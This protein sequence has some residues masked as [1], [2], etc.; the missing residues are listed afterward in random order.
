M[1]HVKTED[2]TVT[3]Y[4]DSYKELYH[5]K[6]GAVE[7]AIKKYVEPCRIIEL[8]EARAASGKLRILDICFGIGYNAIAAIDAAQPS[9]CRVEVISLELHKN[10]LKEIGSL[11]PPLKNYGLAKSVAKRC[12]KPRTR[13][14]SVRSGNTLLSLRLEDARK[15]IKRLPGK[16][17]AVFLDPF[18]VPK[19]PQLWSRDFF[20]AI[21]KLMT[22]SAVLATYSCAG[23]VRA[24]LVNAGFHITNGPELVKR[25][26]STLASKIVFKDYTNITEKYRIKHYISDPKLS[27][28]YGELKKQ[29]W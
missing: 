26:P 16:F 1:K 22:D 29:L 2:G 9:G 12:L 25:R 3:L 24:G 11:E 20:E 17:D 18:S 23:I 8:A 21:R 15:T 19:N 5:S 27:A 28:P 10:V 4:N 13:Q 7:E 14:A 6:G